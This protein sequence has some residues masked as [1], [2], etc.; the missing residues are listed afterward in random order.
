M[1]TWSIGPVAPIINAELMGAVLDGKYYVV[2][3]R[4]NFTSV[5]IFDPIINSWSLGPPLPTGRAGLAVVVLNGLLH[6]IGGR[7][8]TTP[9]AELL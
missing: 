5:Q 8:G 2:G 6:A 7:T 9:V 1:D 4:D 3:G